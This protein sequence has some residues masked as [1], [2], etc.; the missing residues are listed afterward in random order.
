MSSPVKPL[1]S[2][3]LDDIRP[4]LPRHPGDSVEHEDTVDLEDSTAVATRDY[5]PSAEY[6]RLS[7]SMHSFSF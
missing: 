6:Q 4:N 5:R 7:K 2:L 3:A 1:P